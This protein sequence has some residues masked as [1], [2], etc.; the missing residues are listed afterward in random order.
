MPAVL[1]TPCVFLL[2]SFQDSHNIQN[3]E[4]AE[5]G[6]E[7]SGRALG[8]IPAPINNLAQWIDYSAPLQRPHALG[9]IGARYEVNHIALA[10]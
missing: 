2:S 4:Y 10:S 5:Y 8:M 7:H 9:P 6:I 1:Y 3:M